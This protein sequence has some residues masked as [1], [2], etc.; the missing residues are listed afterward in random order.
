MTILQRYQQLLAS[1]EISPDPAQRVAAER[2]DTLARTLSQTGV[3]RS[4]GRGFFGL[5]GGGDAAP[6][7]SPKGVYLYGP[8]G[9]GKSM[10]MDLFHDE[11][12]ITPRRRIHFHEFMQ[13]AHGLIHKQRERGAGGEAYRRDG[14]CQGGQQCSSDSDIVP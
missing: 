8:V 9:R 1:G 5:F 2:L 10:L 13:G 6:V 14:R 7:D 11:V 4:K 12:A 3:E